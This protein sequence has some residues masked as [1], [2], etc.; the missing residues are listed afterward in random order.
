MTRP[1]L[2]LILALSAGCV[3]TPSALAPLRAGFA[4]ADLTPPPGWRRAGGYDEYFSTGVH[5]PLLAKAVVF[6]Q[7]GERGAIVVCDLCSIGR[8]ISDAA[9][10][11]ASRRTGIPVAHI[12]ISATHTHGGPEYYGVLWEA[13]HGSAVE[14]HG[15]DIHEPI[16]YVARVVN[17]C[18]EAIAEAD[19]R[20]TE[21][22]LDH[23][24]ARMTGVAFN[25]RFHLSDGTTVTNPGKRNPKIV[26]PAGPVDEDFPIV[27]FRDLAT[28]KAA[29]SLSTF[30]MHVATYGGPTFGA[31]FPGHLETG[32]RA[33]LGEG[34]ISVFGEG[35]A[36]DTNHFDVSSERPQSSDTEPQRIGAAMTESFLRALPDFRRTAPSL[37]IRSNRVAVP[38]QEVT[39]EQIARARDALALR[40]SPKPA[41]FVSVEAFRVL[42]TEKLRARDGESVREEIQAFRL[43]DEV[44]VVTL[45]HE[46]FVELGLAIRKQSPFR[47]TL[48]VSLANDVDFYVPTR[49]AFAEGGYEVSTSPY[50]PGGGEL[51]VETAVALLQALRR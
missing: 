49:K 11:A 6:E 42:W 4:T 48:V 43:S 19:R 9:R 35:T 18:V 12:V 29:G 36:G 38:L 5:D 14:K 24:I 32:L 3:S 37:S 2:I 47:T 27:L 1:A 45:P 25:R 41:F 15:R 50:K 21:V 28:G 22:S 17:A 7:G 26:R 34:F 13:W 39:P 16:D 40:L 10:Q 30:A 31:D 44:A 51:L 20:K 46:I 33:K 8:D 23:G